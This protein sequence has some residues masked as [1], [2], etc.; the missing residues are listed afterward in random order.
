[1]SGVIY[2]IICIP[3]GLSY[4]GQATNFKVKNGTPYNYGASGRWNDHVSTAKT[5]NTP[6]CIAIRE[7]GRDQFMVEV[8]EEGK[9]EHLDEREADW[10]SRIDCVHPN[11]YNVAKH[12][13]NRHRE[14]SNLHVFYMGRIVSAEIRPIKRSGSLRLVHVYLMLNDQTRERIAFGQKRGTT[15]EQA[16]DDATTFL[17]HLACPYTVVK[18]YSERNTSNENIIKQINSLEI[19]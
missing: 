3:T 13:R 16:V 11:G 1:M 17:N 7:Y 19:Q 8:L 12:S 5:R 10:L 9:L 14:V 6:L 18:H 4:V 15:Y 2:Q